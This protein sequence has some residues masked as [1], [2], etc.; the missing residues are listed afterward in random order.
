MSVLVLDP[1]PVEIGALIERRRRLGL[2]RR[3]ELWDGVLHM[4]PAPHGRHHRVQQ[5]LAQ[6]LGPPAI[7]AG[8]TPAVGEFN[9]GSEHDYRVPDGAVPRSALIELGPGE[10]AERID[11]P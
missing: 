9:L 10:L 5:Q 2:D 6:L 11:W 3:D 8:L 4:N 7:A 1:A